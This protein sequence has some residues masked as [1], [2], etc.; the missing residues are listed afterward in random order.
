MK[1]NLSF[2]KISFPVAVCIF[3]LLGQSQI[4]AGIDFDV[5]GNGETNTEPNFLAV[6]A[7]AAKEYNVTHNGITF[8]ITTTNNNRGNQNRRRGQTDLTALIRDFVQFYGDTGTPVE[9]TITL[10]GLVP[11]ADY[12]LSFFTYNAGAGQTTHNIYDGSSA[13]TGTLLAN[14][15][16]SGTWLT[17]ETWIPN[18][19][20]TLNSGPSG[21]IIATIEAPLKT[22]G[23]S[24]LT[25][26]GMSVT[27]VGE[28]TPLDEP[29]EITSI[30]TD[31][32]TQETTL[33]FT[34]NPNTSYNC[35]SSIDLIEFSTTETPING[36]SLTTDANGN[37]TVTLSATNEKRFF[38]IEPIPT[39]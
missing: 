13:S 39:T 24:R 27:Q 19:V 5:S 3:P 35:F 8:D 28:P 30:L 31:P 16:T 25:L 17:P 36:T 22:N 14:F 10:S 18:F 2:L 9:A 6:P 23:E 34:G 15:T 29:L 32:E 4:T 7:T 33:T 11:N 38:R 12:E 26:D 20:H 1:S 37:G 21:Q